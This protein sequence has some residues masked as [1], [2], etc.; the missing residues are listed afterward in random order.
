MV[1]NALLMN[2]ADN[3]VTTVTE[4]AKGDDVCFMKGSEH[5]ILKAEED[6]P[7]CHK[8]A[9]E[10]IG[11]GCDV[12]KYGESLGHTVADISKGCWVNDHNLKSELRDYDSELAGDDWQMCAEQSEGNPKQASFQFWGYRR[13]EGRPGIR[14]HILI[15]PTCVCASESCRIVASQIRGAVNIV[16]NTGCSDVQANTDMSQKILTGFACHP[17]IYGVVIIGLGCETVPHKRLIE[18]LAD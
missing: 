1:V 7:Y 12:I 5:I 14:N 8:I 15:L 16:F 2:L 11:R 17:N 18:R 9:L 13:P 6:I 4:I 3:V 10:D